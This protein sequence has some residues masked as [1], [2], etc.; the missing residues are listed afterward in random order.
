M[1][2]SLWQRLIDYVPWL[3]QGAFVDRILIFRIKSPKP[4]PGRVFHKDHLFPLWNNLTKGD[5]ESFIETARTPPQEHAVMIDQRLR[6]PGKSTRELGDRFRG[7]TPPA[8]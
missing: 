3:P 7:G 8:G 1:G 2:E 4:I 5:Q 6:K